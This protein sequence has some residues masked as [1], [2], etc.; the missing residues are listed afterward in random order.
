MSLQLYTASLVENTC[1]ITHCTR[2]AGMVKLQQRSIAKEAQHHRLSLWE[3][4]WR[5][6]ST[7]QGRFSYEVAMGSKTV[8][9]AGC[10]LVLHSQC[11]VR[12]SQATPGQG[13]LPAMQPIH[14]PGKR[15][16][17]LEYQF[18]GAA[19]HNLDLHAGLHFFVSW[20]A[21]PRP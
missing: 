5:Q 4:S 6:L 16:Q 2:W 10:K 3:N 8:Q 17:T 19:L 20:A 15:K 21:S 12:L 11:K 7:M 13:E 9:A 14:R 18:R 1:R